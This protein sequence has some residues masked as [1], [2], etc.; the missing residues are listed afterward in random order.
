MHR[1]PS[2]RLFVAVALLAAVVLAAAAGRAAASGGTAGRTVVTTDP[3]TTK[4]LIRNA[5]V[6]LPVGGAGFG[7]A[8]LFPLSLTY[9]FPITGTSPLI[10]HSGGMRFVNLRNGHSA[11]VRNFAI[12]L[13]HA[14]LDADVV[15][16][17]NGVPIADLSNVAVVN[18]VPTA[19]VT[20]NSTA[21]TVLNGAL[22]TSIPFS[23]VPLGT[24]RVYLP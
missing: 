1:R 17:A 6:P 5:V 23:K 3:G 18:G 20:L 22:G 11:T 19:T 10:T 9:S 24:A 2:K 15:G 12:D 4:V 7:F 8:S 21:E 14:Q 16:V 13:A